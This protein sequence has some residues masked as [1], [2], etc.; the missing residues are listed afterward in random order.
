[1]TKYQQLDDAIVQTVRKGGGSFGAILSR[2]GDLAN[3]LAPKDR[4]GFSMAGRLVD[5][6]L[7]A[8]RKSGQLTY[9]RATG[10]KVTP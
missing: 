3:P 8:L 1:M 10:W 9:S 4:W 2:V 6:R 7:Q 5:R